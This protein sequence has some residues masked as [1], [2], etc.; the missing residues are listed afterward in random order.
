[1][2][3]GGVI[4]EAFGSSESR[5][6]VLLSRGVSCLMLYFSFLISRE[7]ASQSCNLASKAVTAA[8]WA[9]AIF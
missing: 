8:D 7:I 6:F 9:S 5:A 3:V 2:F 1:M 4:E